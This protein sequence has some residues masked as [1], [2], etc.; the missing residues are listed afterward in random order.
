MLPYKD[1]SNPSAITQGNPGLVPEFIHNVEFSYS[2]MDN[3]GDNIILSAYYQY[4]QN[5]I[6]RVNHKIDT[7]Q[8]IIPQ[9]LKAGVTYGADVTAHIQFVP[10]VWD[11]LVSLNAFQVNILDTIPALANSGFSWVGKITTNVKLP[12]GFNLQVNGSYESPKAVPQGSLHEVY[13]I[14][15]ALRKNLLKNKAT[16]VLNYSD[17]LNSRKFTTVY[18]P[19]AYFNNNY[20]ETIYKDRESRIGNI[21]FSYRFGKTLDEKP[22]KKG[23]KDANAPD[24]IKDAKDREGNLKGEEGSGDQGQPAKPGSGSN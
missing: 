16:I 10:N 8:Y 12:L 2:K 22:Y 15:V 11:A 14:D 21:T 23:Q 7:I 17:I 19:S 1:V 4:D 3:R 6:E 13:W 9:N 18:T 5:I 20:Y 24:L